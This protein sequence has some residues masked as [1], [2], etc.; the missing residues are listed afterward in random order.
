MQK[1]CSKCNKP[2]KEVGRLVKVTWLGFRAPLCAKCRKEVKRKPKSRFIVDGLF[3][4]L[5]KESATGSRKKKSKK[6]NR[7]SKK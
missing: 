7:K 2:I 6:P 5:R 1:K 3:R 4:R